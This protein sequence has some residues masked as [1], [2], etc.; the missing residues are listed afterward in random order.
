M[1]NF[2]PLQ[3]PG[4]HRVL[5]GEGQS[6]RKG[7]FPEHSVLRLARVF[8]RFQGPVEEGEQSYSQRKVQKCVQVLAVTA[9]FIFSRDESRSAIQ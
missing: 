3:V 6:R 2:D 1:S 9:G 5:L 7:R 8:L 4:A